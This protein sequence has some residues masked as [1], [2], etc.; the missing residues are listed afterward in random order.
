MKTRQKLIAIAAFCLSA[1]VMP[2]QLIVNVIL[3]PQI[4]GKISDLIEQADDIRLSITN[5]TPEDLSF[6]ILGHVDVDDARIATVGFAIS[7]T[8]VAPA[9]QNRIITLRELDVLRDAIDMNSPAV[10]NIL[11]SG[12]LPAGNLSWCFR[13]VSASN[14]NLELAPEQCKNKVVTAY[15]APIALQPLEGESLEPNKL[16]I[17]R[18]TPV[19]PSF[20]GVLE[21]RLQI[22]EILPGQEPMQAFRSNQPLW[23]RSS[24][25]TQLNWPFEVPRDPGNYLWTVRA[26]DTEGDPV[27][28]VETFAEFLRF[29][30]KSPESPAGGGAADDFN[31]ILSEG[32]V[33]ASFAPKGSK[34][35]KY[36]MILPT[37]NLEAARELFA[38]SD[39]SLAYDLRLSFV[40][41]IPANAENVAEAIFDWEGNLRQVFTADGPVLSFNREPANSTLVG[42]DGGVVRVWTG[43]GGG[44]FDADGKGTKTTS[45]RSMGK[46]QLL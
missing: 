24:P 26:F 17:F 21:Y 35:A 44:V 25:S 33:L 43:N 8:E 12:Y 31:Q 29:S 4:P 11:R 45:A 2:A 37:K 19:T 18:W 23:E 5:P 28:A 39:Q 10:I 9:G 6:R 27:G 15:Q 46:P 30:I 1:Y 40:R 42:L 14:P 34:Q 20:L 22:F 41:E 3:P 7:P 32:F 36:S 13:L 16:P 38:A